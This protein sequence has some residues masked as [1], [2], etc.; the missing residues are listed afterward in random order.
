MV[1][2]SERRRLESQYSAADQTSGVVLRSA[3]GLLLIAG[4]AMLGV[5]AEQQ[6]APPASISASQA[7]NDR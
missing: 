5:A 1:Y 6:S 3:A 2:A 4:I 7:A